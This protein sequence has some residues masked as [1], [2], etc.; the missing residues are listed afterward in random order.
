MLLGTSRLVAVGR[1]CDPN[2]ARDGRSD[3]S[4]VGH[5]GG[6]LRG[7]AP[8]SPREAP[9]AERWRLQVGPA[10][11]LG[12]TTGVAVG[13]MVSLDN[14][15]GSVSDSDCGGVGFENAG[16][17][18]RATVIE[19]VLPEVPAGAHPVQATLA[20]HDTTPDAAGRMSVTGYTGQ[21]SYGGPPPTAPTGSILVTP[22]ASAGRDSWDVTALVTEDSLELGLVGFW[23]RLEPDVIGLHRFTCSGTTLGPI[24]TVEY[25]GDPIPIPAE[26]QLRVG[27]DLGT[28]NE[29][30]KADEDNGWWFP[31]SWLCGEVGRDVASRDGGQA[32]GRLQAHWPAL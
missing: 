16:T 27:G 14:Q 18:E 1:D 7:V 3:A 20:I 25:V 9:Q 15:W 10:A 4:P 5:V 30:R 31:T 32:C 8:A 21:G 17:P 13:G 24:L 29:L 12:P 11:G 19:F 28:S 26:G 23:L 6:G 22:A 2:V